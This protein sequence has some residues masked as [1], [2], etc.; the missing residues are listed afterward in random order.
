MCECVCRGGNE[1]SDGV[2][3]NE[4]V[5][6]C[7]RE[8]VSYADRLTHAWWT[9]ACDQYKVLCNIS[10]GHTRTHHAAQPAA[11]QRRTKSDD[12][13]PA[14]PA[15]AGATERRARATR[16]RRAMRDAWTVYVRGRASEND[17]RRHRY[18][19]FDT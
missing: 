7:D 11:A 17:M 19:F 18:I 16:V 8:E 10:L 4:R 2:S 6:G 1:C 14:P 5:T 15:N 3:Q 9:R 12:Q 13:R